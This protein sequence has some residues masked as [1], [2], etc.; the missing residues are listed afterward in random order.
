L[1]GD[2]ARL[3]DVLA[4]GAW[5]E[6]LKTEAEGRRLALEIVHIAGPLLRRGIV[7]GAFVFRNEWGVL[8][9]YT[10]VKAWLVTYPLIRNRTMA[11]GTSA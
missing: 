4:T 3:L 1:C 2:I 10:D 11:T 7:D 6:F 5:E 9:L 8:N